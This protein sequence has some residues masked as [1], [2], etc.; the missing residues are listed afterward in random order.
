MFAATKFRCS[1][2]LDYWGKTLFIIQL[3]D[4]FGKI[5]GYYVTDKHLYDIQLS[6]TSNFLC[7]KYLL[8]NITEKKTHRTS[9]YY[10]L[11]ILCVVVVVCFSE[12][13]IWF[14]TESFTCW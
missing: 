9:H 4:T 1:Y 7:L 13:I 2:S 6:K 8:K 5:V 3:P 14:K 12:G 10:T 11:N